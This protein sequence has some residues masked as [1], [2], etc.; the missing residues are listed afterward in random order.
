MAP[1]GSK[2]KAI[3][4]AETGA[5]DTAARTEEA[6][7]EQELIDTADDALFVVDTVGE[8][9]DCS[10]WLLSTRIQTYFISASELDVEL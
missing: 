9:C 2:R 3:K 1:R 10:V 6:A 7:A 8:C 4:R 5:E